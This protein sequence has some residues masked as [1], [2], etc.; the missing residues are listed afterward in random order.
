MTSRPQKG[1]YS[2]HHYTTGDMCVHYSGGLWLL[3]LIFGSFLACIRTTCEV[4]GQRFK[5]LRM[6]TYLLFDAI[7]SC[8]SRYSESQMAKYRLQ[9]YQLFFMT[10]LQ[11]VGR[12]SCRRPLLT[13]RLYNMAAVSCRWLAFWIRTEACSKVAIT[14][15]AT[16]QTWEET[17]R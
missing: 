2:L 7:D 14:Q 3:N 17:Q 11:Y 13:G 9:Y 16:L 5:Y 12:L 8:K 15:P 4:Y 1:G 6:H 10:V